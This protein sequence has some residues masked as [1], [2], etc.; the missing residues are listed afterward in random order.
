MLHTL[1]DIAF[2]PFSVEWMSSE[3]VFIPTV[4]IFFCAGF[5][6]IRRLITIGGNK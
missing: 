2:A 1:L 3:L 5:S 4:V 6:L